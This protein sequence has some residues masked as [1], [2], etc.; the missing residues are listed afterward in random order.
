MNRIWRRY[1]PFI[2]TGIQGLI[3]YRVDFILYRIGDVIGA[4]VA[5]QLLCDSY[6]QFILLLPTFSWRLVLDGSSF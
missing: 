1:K 3:T 4:F 5:F 2:S 6:V